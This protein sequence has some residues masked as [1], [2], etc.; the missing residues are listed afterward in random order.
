MS[1][2]L[3]RKTRQSIPSDEDEDQEEEEDEEEDNPRLSSRQTRQ[4]QQPPP[5][6]AAR[7]SSLPPQTRSGAPSSSTRDG[8][9]TIG[10]K[11]ADGVRGSFRSQATKTLAK[12]TND[13]T[14]KE[15]PP[16][17]QPGFFSRLF[18]PKSTPPPPPP[19]TATNTNSR[20]CSIM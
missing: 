16:A 9:Q 18:G 12:P 13:A 3:N 11:P 7:R 1:E 14:K 8:N 5:P 20:A 6:T 2:T 19:P 17:Q 4:K 10:S 15:T